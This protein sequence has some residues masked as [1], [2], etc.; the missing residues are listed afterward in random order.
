[1]SSAFVEVVITEWAAIVEHLE[2]ES[3]R[4]EADAATAN[5]LLKVVASARFLGML[6][7]LADLFPALSSLS[8]AFQKDSLAICDMPY[9]ISSMK[10]N[11]RK[12]REGPCSKSHFQHFKDTLNEEENT[13]SGQTVPIKHSH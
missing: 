13:F 4:K 12:M 7:F 5:G 6:H 1:M 8:T 3:A 2:G 9:L 11:L 10:K